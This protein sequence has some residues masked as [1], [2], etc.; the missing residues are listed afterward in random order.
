MKK[1]GENSEYSEDKSAFLHLIC[2]DSLIV[3]QYFFKRAVCLATLFLYYLFCSVKYLYSCIWK[4]FS[5]HAV[6]EDYGRLL[7]SYGKDDNHTEK[8]S[9]SVKANF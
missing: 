1:A 2:Y 8:Q 7:E 9:L 5:V 4:Y 3:Q 6:L